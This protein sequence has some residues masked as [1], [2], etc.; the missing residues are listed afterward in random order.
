MALAVVAQP[1]R[2]SDPLRLN[3][4]GDEAEDQKVAGSNPAN[5][6]LSF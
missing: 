6:I 5:G 1:G 4:S 2:A 3:L